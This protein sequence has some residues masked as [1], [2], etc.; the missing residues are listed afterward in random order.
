MVDGSRKKILKNGTVKVYSTSRCANR[1]CG[2]Q[3]NIEKNILFSFTD[4]LSRR[5]SKLDMRTI[6]ELIWLWYL[7][8]LSSIIGTLLDVTEPTILDW[9]KFL[10]IFR[11]FYL[12]R[13]L[14]L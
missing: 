8:T 9:T 14:D 1:G 4:A 7:R 6:L 3:L 13:I 12:K 2:S 11:H 5:N 10:K